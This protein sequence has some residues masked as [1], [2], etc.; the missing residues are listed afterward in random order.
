MY[1]MEETN[2]DLPDSL[3]KQLK[4][5]HIEDLHLF[6]KASEA[7][8]EAQESVGESGIFWINSYLKVEMLL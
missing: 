2:L 7:E 8:L 6:Q 5:C 3:F 4:D 1:M